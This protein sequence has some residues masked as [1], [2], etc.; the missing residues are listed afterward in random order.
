MIGSGIFIVSA[1]ILR[2]CTT[3]GLLLAGVADI[4][5]GDTARSADVR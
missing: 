5:R 3:P 4:G 2:Q 1:E